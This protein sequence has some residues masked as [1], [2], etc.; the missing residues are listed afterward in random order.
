MS[1]VVS[2]D[3]A[4]RPAETV[5]APQHPRPHPGG[6]DRTNP[7]ELTCRGT[8]RKTKRRG[9]R[10][11][12][13]DPKFV[14]QVFELA[15][16]GHS[17]NSI[18]KLL[19][20][21]KDSVRYIME[22]LE[23]D[24]RREEATRRIGVALPDIASMVATDVLGKRDR[25]LGHQIL[26]RSGVYEGARPTKTADPTEGRIVIEWSGAP[27]PWAP[28]TVLNAH[29]A[30]AGKEAPMTEPDAPVTLRSGAHRA[31]PLPTSVA[32]LDNARLVDKVTNAPKDSEAGPSP[33]E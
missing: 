10:T 18:R 6:F 7:P 16:Q 4:D 17:A 19:H 9:S 8:P 5:P 24:K 22:V 30:V 26:D 13:K 27:P 15:M 3:K 12:I 33:V 1:D 2:I 14:Q 11:R 28:A 29:A 31:D 21:G 20:T 23:V 32:S 25:I